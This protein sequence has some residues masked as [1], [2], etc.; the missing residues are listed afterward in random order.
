LLSRPNSVRPEWNQ[1]L[2]GLPVPTLITWGDQDRLL[3]VSGADILKS[4]IPD[5]EVIVMKN[6]G[7]TPMI[8]RPE[9]TAIAFL[10]FQEK[11]SSK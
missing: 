9:E 10:R 6:T 7:H 2:K 5:A 1:N 4:A 8:E 3:D 11:V